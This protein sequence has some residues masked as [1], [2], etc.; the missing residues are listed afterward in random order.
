MSSKKIIIAWWLWFI[1]VNLSKYFLDKWHFLIIIDNL[2]S[3]SEENIE[4]FESNKNLIFINSDICDININDEIFLW[5]NE[6]YNL[7]TIASPK[8][9][10]Q[11]WIETIKTNTIWLLNLLEVAR[12]YNAKFFQSS[13]SEIY[14]DPICF[15]QSEEY[16]W[17]VNC[18]WPRSCYDEGKRVAE[19]LCYEYIKRYNLD[20]KI[21][22]IFNVF[23]PYMQV[24]DGRVIPNFINNALSG[25][26]L[27][28]YWD[29]KQ[30]RS[31]MY[32]DDLIQGIEKL[33]LSDFNSPVNLWSN[34]NICILDLAKYILKITNSS[35]DI[36]FIESLKDDPIIR[37]PDISLAINKLGWSP[38]ISLEDGIIYCIK[39]FK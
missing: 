32:I 8:R 24:D 35:S 30:T 27:E 13:T 14:W 29:W 17:N 28:I 21:W 38:Q 2:V 9:Y 34:F 12:K 33:M 18:F 39:Y 25:K 3:S 10:Q 6:I 5:V 23:W 31:F 1:W 4:V 11:N 26:N 19:S 36:K 22:R 20:I 7:A 37:N 15:V 16:L